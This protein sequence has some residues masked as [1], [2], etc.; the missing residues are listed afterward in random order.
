MSFPEKSTELIL[1]LSFIISVGS[2]S[3]GL[4]EDDNSAYSTTPLTAN[5][6]VGLKYDIE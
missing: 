4:I 3:E 1:F 5:G 6:H 2:E